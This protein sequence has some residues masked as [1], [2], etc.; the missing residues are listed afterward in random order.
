MRNPLLP[1]RLDSEIAPARYPPPAED[2]IGLARQA[3]PP[4]SAPRRRRS[5]RPSRRRSRLRRPTEA[6]AV[7]RRCDAVDPE[8]AAAVEAGQR[9]CRRAKPAALPNTT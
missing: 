3:P 6:A 2:H 9:E 1:F 4:G 7:G 5:G 8:A